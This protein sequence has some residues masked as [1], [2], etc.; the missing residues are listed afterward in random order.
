VKRVENIKRYKERVFLHSCGYAW[1][2][3][4]L[5]ID[6]GV[7]CYQS[8]QTGTGMDIQSLHEA[9][10]KKISFWGNRPRLQR[11]NR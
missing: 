7:C 10:G 5:F 9:F 2:L 11:A 6:A 1:D 8:L 4:D 3:M